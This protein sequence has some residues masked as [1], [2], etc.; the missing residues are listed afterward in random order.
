N[1][2]NTGR[3][4]LNWIHQQI[5]KIEKRLAEFKKEEQGWKKH[6]IINELNDKLNKIDFKLNKKVLCEDCKREKISK[7]TDK[8]GNEGIARFLY[9]ECK[10]NAYNYD[11]KYIRWIPF[12]EF[13]N[14]E[15]LSKD[16]FVEVDK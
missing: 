1:C 5:N 3:S 16:G 14:I 8:Y 9:Y 2:N 6:R 4:N 15:Y 12:D 11:S 7:L 10:L 13:K